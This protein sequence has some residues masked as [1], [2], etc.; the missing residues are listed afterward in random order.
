[1]VYHDR[2]EDGFFTGEMVVNSAQGNPGILG[3]LA[4][5]RAVIAALDEKLVGGGDNLCASV[6]SSAK[7][8][9]CH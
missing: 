6:A 8:I 3:N 5:G 7:I 9:F 4:H 2:D 1:V